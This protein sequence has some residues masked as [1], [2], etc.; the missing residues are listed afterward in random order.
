[1][2]QQLMPSTLKA[3]MSLIDLVGNWQPALDCDQSPN[4]TAYPALSHCSMNVSTGNEV[5]TLTD[6]RT[7]IPDKGRD[8]LLFPHV[9]CQVTLRLKKIWP[10]SRHTSCL[11]SVYE[12][13]DRLTLRLR[14]EPQQVNAMYRFVRTSQETHYVSAMS[15]NR[16]MLSIGFS[17]PHRK[18]ITSPL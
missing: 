16:L 13:H 7:G 8:L 12:K 11:R 4:Q 18:H 17:V 6:R 9:H 15:P 10:A 2:I 14:Y 5:Y 3:R 1:M